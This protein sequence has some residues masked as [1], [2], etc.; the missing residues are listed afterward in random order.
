MNEPTHAFVAIFLAAFLTLALTVF[1][2]FATRTMR[3]VFQTPQ[4]A[5][6]KVY[7][8]MPLQRD[9]PTGYGRHAGA[10]ELIE[11]DEFLDVWV[12]MT[13]DQKDLYCQEFSADR[14]SVPTY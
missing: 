7:T 12:K 1:S 14:V 6:D 11:D 8:P 4:E 13:E 2:D 5:A 3:E 10:Q 9:Q